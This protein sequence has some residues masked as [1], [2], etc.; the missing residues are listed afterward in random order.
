ML[1]NDS[2]IPRLKAYH[3]LGHVD[4]I[5]EDALGLQRRMVREGPL[6]L[7]RLGV[8]D[9][10][11]VS[12]PALL[13]ELLVERA[14]DFE[15]T[16]VLRDVLA[17][18]IGTGILSSQGSQHRRRRAIVN[19]GFQA[20]RVSQY[21]DAIVRTT[22]E[23][24]D[25][26]AAQAEVEVDAAMMRLTLEAVCATLFH[27]PVAGDVQAVGEAVTE[28]SEAATRI[29]RSP[30]PLPMTIARHLPAGKALIDAGQ[31]L[32]AVVYRIIRKRRESGEDPGDVLS[33][34]LAARD[35]GSGEPLSDEALRDEVMTLFLAGHETTAV[36]L[37]WCLQLVSRH[38]EVAH[39]LESEVDAVLGDRVPTAADLPRLPYCLAV[40][41]EAMRLYPPAYL[42][43]RSA[44]IDTRIGGHTVKRGALVFANIYG[45]HRDPA[46][47]PEPDA[48]KP[49][50]FLD[51]A[52]KRWPKGAYMPFSVGPRV[53]VGNHFAMMEGQLVIARMAQRFALAGSIRAFAEPEPMIT[54][55]PDRRV[56]MDV[57]LR[58][59]RALKAAS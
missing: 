5:R 34:L 10:I 40:F 21:A 29:F 7:T 25:T 58:H 23:V 54:L 33:M 1:R 45:V 47:F 27:T 51:G 3:L 15:K 55:R 35:A 17:P 37:L 30:V 36:G 41:K 44:L 26:M 42:V 57:R 48:F 2:T 12:S 53:C 14:E 49:E 19:P 28:G 32:D 13:T 52:E 11:W 59:G 24:L 50:R 22:D 46:L 4:A 8:I 31:K 20:G 39:K 6:M 9:A 56:P 18:L 43:G 38:A 16:Q